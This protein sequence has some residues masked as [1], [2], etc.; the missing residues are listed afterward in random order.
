MARVFVSHATE[1]YPV[2]EELCAWL[3]G[4]GHRVFLDHDVSDGIDLGEVW[5]KRLYHELR[6]A[7]AVVCVITEAYLRSEWCTA[8][9]GI[10]D[11]WGLRLLPLRADPGVTS[12]LLDG[13]QY[14]DLRDDWRA[15]FGTSLRRIGPRGW[16]RSRSP[17]PG[18]R[19]FQTDMAPAFHGRKA[20]VDQLA[21]RLRAL[22][23]RFDSGILLLVGPSGCGKSSLVRAGL[24]A[25][26]MAEPGWDV[27]RPFTPGMDPVG[28]LA[29]ALVATANGLRLEWTV[30]RTR[31]E[32]SDGNGLRAAA[33][34]L[35]VAG[36]DP[37]RDRLLVVVDQAEELLRPG[38]ED[39]AQFATLI[40]KAVE[41][42]LRVVM[43]LRS[44][45]QDQLLSLPELA[46]VGA[47]VVPLRPLSHDM[48]RV[49]IEEPARLCDLDIEDELVDRLITDTGSGSAL[50]LLA[51]T[52][53]RLAEGGPILTSARYEE[54]GGVQGALIRHADATLVEAVTSSGVTRDDVLAA[55]VR[56]ASFD[57]TRRRIDLNGL[58]EPLRVAFG[59]FVDQRLLTAEHNWVEVVHEALL[60]E[61]PPLHAAIEERKVAL[62]AARSVELAAADWLTAKVPDHLLWDADRL[63]AAGDAESVA[64]LSAE[65]K[66]FLDASRAKVTR[67]RARERRRRNR[68]VSILSVLVVL[69]A[70]AAVFAGTQWGNAN[71]NKRVAA[72]R[73]LLS[74][75][76]AMQ[77]T[78]TGTS[79]RLGV[80]AMSVNA[81]SEARAGLVNTLMGNHYVATLTG[82]VNEV[83][84]VAFS[85]DGRLMVTGGA[86]PS[87][88]LWDVSDP[89][90]PR[91]V[92]S[93]DTEGSVWTIVI[94]HDGRTMVTGGPTMV[95]VWDI[96]NPADPQWLGAVDEAPRWVSSAALSEDDHTLITGIWDNFGANNEA[97]LWDLSDRTTPRKLATLSADNSG[98]VR[99]VA[100]SHDRRVAITGN[101]DGTVL[102]WDIADQTA[103]RR[104]ATLP[105]HGNSVWAVATS[106]DGRT[107]LT[108]GA[109]QTAILWDITDPA[110][111]AR[112]S[113]LN[114]HS[115]TVR[116]VAFSPDGRTV[117]TGSFDHTVILWRVDDLSRPVRF[118]TLGGHRQPVFAVAFS[119]D[120]SHLATGS[121]DYTTVL[122]RTDVAADPDRLGELAGHRNGLPSL[123]FSPDGH[124]MITGGADGV[125]IA[126]EVT[127]LRRPRPLT[128]ISAHVGG[129]VMALNRDGT[130][131]LT[132]SADS[133]AVLWDV[134]DWA[135]PRQL[136]MLEQGRR[137]L[138]AVSFVPE[139]NIVALGGEDGQTDLWNIAD[140]VR[141][142][143]LTTI[144]D[145]VGRTSAVP[146]SPD[147]RRLVTGNT[148]STNVVWDVSDPAQP[149][150]LAIHDDE[151]STYS[152]VFSPDGRT[153]ALAQEGRKTTLLDLSDPGK[154]EVLAVMRGQASSVY[155]AGFSPDGKV[156][157]TGGYDKTAIFWDVTDL[158][159]P[160]ELASVRGHASVVGVV[161][162]SPDRHTV[163]ISGGDTPVLWDI[164][165]LTDL[166]ARPVEIACA[167]VGEELTE[168]QWSTYAPDIAYHRTC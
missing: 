140:P 11:A 3:R 147:G 97:I 110:K 34:E 148:D 124:R 18:L 115:G 67:T 59:V 19:S 91:R 101:E 128:R 160:R 108:G 104:I 159:N 80:A 17:F 66:D 106:P 33:A 7:D 161:L 86:D 92:G 69:F 87:V 64:D 135:R 13:R 103:P 49:I 94:S 39:L 36:A 5:R 2:A 30:A 98:P 105:D 28:A 121:S 142:R 63:A 85:P 120:G 25:T 44:E 153:L 123:V 158:H 42:S 96:G 131:L 165:Q 143:K 21:A 12:R 107:L 149:R 95:V 112:L 122:W 139:G 145:Q 10:A 150:Q 130:R 56:L 137:E 68:F 31:R 126:W 15:K 61:W 53:Q 54:I 35:L 167:I 125:M 111:P 81:S 100:L 45:F 82:H 99:G 27:L 117:A 50:P 83:S 16:D 134:T 58:A 32:L 24:A 72:G 93:T 65:A 37:P 74:Q 136:A 46:R 166:V 157:G 55:L 38:Q 41:G 73:S 1:D 141:P 156:L 43:T 22:D 47:D 164:T 70:A 146:F 52:L 14:V 155:A 151:N 23:T 102:V 118:D 114:G 40:V 71:D 129:F 75:A 163:A 26:M 6:A 4:E 88:I 76:E 60:T 8:E 79:L 144:G 57:Q 132:G 9:V 77:N 51:F 133:T 20:E 109:D 119:H 113:S 89:D 78:E 127:D 154:P 62:L 116:A 48:L 152:G 90:H 138:S 84:A 29:Q 162:F 168:Q